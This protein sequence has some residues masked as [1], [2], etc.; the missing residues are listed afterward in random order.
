MHPL[1]IVLV[2]L[3]FL[4]AMS[5]GEREAGYGLLGGGGVRRKHRNQNRR[6]DQLKSINTLEMIPTLDLYIGPEQV[7]VCV[8]YACFTEQANALLLTFHIGTA[9]LIN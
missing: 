8:C 2:L 1:S 6:K 9:M 7:C 4:I 3:F 5:I